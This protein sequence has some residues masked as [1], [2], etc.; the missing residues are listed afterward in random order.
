MGLV[1]GA[2]ALAEDGAGAA[3]ALAE[4]GAAGAE[5]LAEDGAGAAVMAVAT[6]GMEDAAGAAGVGITPTRTLPT[7]TMP[8]TMAMGTTTLQ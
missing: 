7:A 8:L 6:E 1:V 4:D 5:A 3:E 2:E